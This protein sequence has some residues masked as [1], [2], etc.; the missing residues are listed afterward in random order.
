MAL[1]T[2]RPLADSLL[3]VNAT[4]L[5]FTDN[6]IFEPEFHQSVYV[7]ACKT[8]SAAPGAFQVGKASGLIYGPV[9]G[10]QP[11]YADDEDEPGSLEF[12]GLVLNDGTVLD[13]DGGSR[14]VCALKSACVRQ[15]F[16]DFSLARSVTRTF[17]EKKHKAQVK[18]NDVLI[19]STGDGTIGRVAVYNADFPAMVDGHITILR[20]KDPDFA[21]YVGAFL[22]SEQGQLQ[23]YRYINGSSGQV[24]IYP[25]DIA[26]VW[27]KPPQSTAKKTA[28]ADGLREAANLHADFYKKLRAAL[29]AF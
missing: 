6:H 16:I 15:G 19:N 17:F 7:Q 27:V 8:T 25:Q 23:M 11:D 18:R 4:E 21:W 5:A 10:V 24:E 29:S 26:R 20:F 12:G 28:V 14:N 2:T 3:Q 22:L 1:L 9:R 13:D